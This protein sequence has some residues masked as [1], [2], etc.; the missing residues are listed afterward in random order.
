M[1][2]KPKPGDPCPKP[3]CGG[4]INC[5]HTDEGAVDHYDNFYHRCGTCSAVVDHDENFTCA[6]CEM[7][8]EKIVCPMCGAEHGTR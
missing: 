2:E 6:G 7:G 5:V 3:G 1:A 4:T 8:N